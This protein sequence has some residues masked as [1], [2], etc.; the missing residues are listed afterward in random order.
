MGEGEVVQAGTPAEDEAEN[1][2][3]TSR[4]ATAF[5]WVLIVAALVLAVLGALEIWPD[6]IRQRSDPGWIDNVFAS[7]TVLFAARVVLFS[8][9]IVLFFG[10]IYTIVSVVVRMKHRHWLRRIG[11]FEVSEQAVTDLRQEA[12]YQRELA[13]AAQEDIASLEQRLD[14]TEE[15]AEHFY[16]L[17]HDVVDEG[18]RAGTSP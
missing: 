5:G 2:E 15:L 3:G 6:E 16:D 8:L 13:D 14:E 1:A 9:A 18:G 12:E 10:A 11:P 4:L 7:K 17:W